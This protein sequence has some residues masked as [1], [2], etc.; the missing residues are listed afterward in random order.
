M[1]K[2]RMRKT[3]AITGLA[4]VLTGFVAACGGGGRV[5][6]GNGVIARACMAAGRSAANSGSCSCIQHVA[7]RTLSASDQTRAAGFFA[8][9]H[10]SQETRQ[11]DGRSSEA[12]WQRYK[13]FGATAEASC[14]G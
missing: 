1:R 6:G 5:G 4:L 14:G 13:A 9:P 11:A 10:A 12:F 3:V 8:D 2:T 7:D